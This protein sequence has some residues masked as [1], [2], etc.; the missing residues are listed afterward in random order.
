MPR[1]V[2]ALFLF[3]LALAGLAV[4]STYRATFHQGLDRLAAA[5]QIRVD[6]AGERLA[7]QLD[8][9]RVLVNLIARDPRT[10]VSLRGA[11]E[12][13]DTEFF[14]RDQVLRFG[15]ERIEILDHEGR[16]V[17]SSEGTGAAISRQGA[18][19]LRAALAGQLGRDH[20]LEAGKRLV[21]FS[22]G[23][24][25]GPA[26]PAGAVILSVDIAAYE[27][28]W[29]VIPEAIG[30]FDAGGLVIASNRPSL[31]LRQAGADP[32]D[33]FAAFPESTAA[34]IGGFEIRRFSGAGDLPSEALV[35]A[36]NVPRIGL[37]ARGFLDT[38]PARATAR[39]RAGLVAALAAALGLL[40]L[41]I[42]LW[43]R[44]VVDRLA[45]EAAANARLEAR[46][47]DRTAE[48]RATQDQ[49]VQASKMTALGQMSAGIS[50]ELNQPLAAI[51]N[52][53]ENGRLLLDRDR[54]DEAGQNLARITEQVQRIDRIVKHLRGFARNES[55]ALEPVDFGATVR[56]ALALVD[57]GM[58]KSGVEPALNLPA[59]VMVLGGKVRLQQV[60]V[61]LLGNAMDAMAECRDKRLTITLTRGA[62]TARL[63]IRDTG[64]GIADL[65]RLFEP[66]YTT[67][68][69][70]ASKGLGLGLSIS[71]GIIGS[72][73]GELDATNPPGG[74]AEFTITLPLTDGDTP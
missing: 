2:T 43:R 35:V 17:A 14:L 27:F 59:D 6:Q 25:D 38:A 7:N 34:R 42:F 47:E 57:V 62:G 28:E 58:R 50:H 4:W 23:V 69:L 60:I 32:A 54:G 66:F 37:T 71:Y 72:F 67:K 49:L 24:F 8:S 5:G 9:A 11:G 3:G 56:D 52:F 73:G 44:R 65:T 61:N 46:V 20:G 48:L 10:L 70:G 31:L 63:A 53:A 36:R 15:A 74:G 29:G 30:F 19:L 45:I 41:A 40:S 64:P 16:V 51:M 26:P 33:R 21:R 22:H 13:A 39:L 12:M 18:P 68:D 1:P 55:E